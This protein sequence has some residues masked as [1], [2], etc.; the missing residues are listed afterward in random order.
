MANAFIARMALPCKTTTNFSDEDSNPDV[1][2]L[3]GLAMSDEDGTCLAHLIS[4]PIG[5]REIGGIPYIT[6]WGPIMRITEIPD[7]PDEFKSQMIEAARSA[8][9]QPHLG[10]D[11]GEVGALRSLDAGRH[12]AIYGVD[13]TPDMISDGN[14]V[15]GAAPSIPN[16]AGPVFSR[17]EVVSARRILGAIAQCGEYVADLAYDHSAALKGGRRTEP[18]SEEL[19]LK[20]AGLGLVTATRT[21]TGFI[22]RCPKIGPQLD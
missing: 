2:G 16:R 6:G 15:K 7:L 5:S 1:A 21:P 19:C 13:T 11:N 10:Q 18:A 22:L 20:L 3:Q 14:N 12:V 8:R 17:D 9:R 4:R